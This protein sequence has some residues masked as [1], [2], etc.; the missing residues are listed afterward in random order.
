MEIGAS[1]RD[2]RLHGEVH[3]SGVDVPSIPHRAELEP[4]YA[5][6]GQTDFSAAAFAR[7][8]GPVTAMRVPHRG[9]Y[10]LNTP[11]SDISGQ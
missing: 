11:I 2:I 7:L 10:M 4:Y 5:V 6:S 1:S 8:L 9:S 3:V